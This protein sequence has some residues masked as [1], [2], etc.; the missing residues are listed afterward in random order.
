MNKFKYIKILALI[1]VGVPFVLLLLATIFATIKINEQDRTY[2]LKP[3]HIKKQSSALI[4]PIIEQ[5]P[6][7]SIY[8]KKLEQDTKQMTPKKEVIK[9][10]KDSVISKT[11]IVDSIYE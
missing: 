10:N 2:P 3:I 11:V 5:K 9:V 1:T 6:A 8:V 7:E 4:Q